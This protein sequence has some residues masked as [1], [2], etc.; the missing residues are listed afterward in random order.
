[1]GGHLRARAVAAVVCL[2]LA[3]AAAALAAT[4]W[5]ARAN[6]ACTK[7][8]K[9]QRAKIAKLRPPR[10]QAQ[11]YAFL[12]QVRPLEV[13]LLNAIVAINGP[14]P[15][16]AKRALALAH[17]DVAELDAAAKAYRAGSRSFNSKFTRWFS[18][19]RADAAFLT[20]GARACAG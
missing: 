20:A 8:H 5:A 9:Q 18:D 12:R 10:N 19:R 4:T 11:A 6:A 14:R 2:V 16:A 13:Q 15:P 7:I 1:M 3:F 17:A